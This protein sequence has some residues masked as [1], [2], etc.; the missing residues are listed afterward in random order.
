MTTP[1]QKYLLSQ[2]YNQPTLGFNSFSNLIK[3]MNTTYNLPCHDKLMPDPALPDRIQSFKSILQKEIEELDDIFINK[4]IEYQFSSQLEKGILSE[5][6]LDSYVALADLLGDVVV[7]CFSE[8]AR[9]GI[10]MGP[11]L[12]EIMKSNF[13]KL[14]E[15]GLP[16]KDENDKFLKGPNYVPPEKGI[17]ERLRENL[18]DLGKN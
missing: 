10:E 8:A 11:V 4:D 2:F 9:H 3:E 7:Y 13:T 14:G 6:V 12:Y 18:S 16:I 17:K 1:T 5:E 15:D